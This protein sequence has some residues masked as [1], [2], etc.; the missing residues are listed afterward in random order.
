LRLKYITYNITNKNIQKNIVAFANE[1][2]KEK[3]KFCSW[4]VGKIKIEKNEISF[5][6]SGFIF[7][8]NICITA[9]YP[10]FCYK[11]ILKNDTLE[12][13]IDN[14]TLELIV[15]TIDN[16]VEKTNDYLEALLNWLYCCK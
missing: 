13:V 8:G 5:S 7:C 14:V 9:S 3:E 2:L 10:D 6:V 4:G 11:I 16:E 12:K 1:L 15:E